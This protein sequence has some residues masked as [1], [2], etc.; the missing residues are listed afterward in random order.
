MK[1][2]WHVCW[3]PRPQVLNHNVETVPRLYAGLR[4]GAEFERSL[5]VLR[6]ARRMDSRVVTKSGLMLGLGEETEEVLQVMDALREVGCQILTLGQYLAPSRRHHPIQRFLPPDEFAAL[7]Q[8]AFKRG[9]L[10]VASEPLVRSSYRAKAM[11][12]EA[13]NSEY[14][15][16]G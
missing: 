9:F 4:P 1:Q 12:D 3:R 11:W 7:G 13:K 2:P 10:A 16:V 5:D 6:R 8:E 15:Q 14:R